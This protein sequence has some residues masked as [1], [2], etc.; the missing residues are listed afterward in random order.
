MNLLS[1]FVCRAMLPE[2]NHPL[3]RQ[4]IRVSPEIDAGTQCVG[5]FGSVTQLIYRINKVE[6]RERKR[7]R[8][9]DQ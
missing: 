4:T 2:S 9:R 1:L 5:L 3:K 8:G 7:E 6:E